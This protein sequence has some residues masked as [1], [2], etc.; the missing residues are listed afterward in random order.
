M[1][2]WERLSPDLQADGLSLEEIRRTVVASG[3]DKEAD[4]ES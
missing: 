1:P 4:L 2:A 3:E